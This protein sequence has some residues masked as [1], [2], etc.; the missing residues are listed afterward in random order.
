MVYIVLVLKG[1]GIDNADS[2]Y[3]KIF[4]HY[5]DAVNY[6][7]YNTDLDS[8]YWTYCQVVKDGEEVWTYKECF[9]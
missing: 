8:K 1:K 4:D 6:C 5:T 7:E 9:C 3:V 2:S